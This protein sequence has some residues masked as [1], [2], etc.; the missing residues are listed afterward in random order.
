MHYPSLIS[1]IKAR[2]E[3]LHVTQ[4]QLAAVS[5]VSSRTLKAFESGKGNPTLETLIKLGDALGLELSFQVKQ[6][7]AAQIDTKA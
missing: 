3:M 4:E 2:R 6:K 7:D 5:G 1:A